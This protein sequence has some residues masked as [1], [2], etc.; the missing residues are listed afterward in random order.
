MAN[1]L[2]HFLANKFPFNE[3]AFS[4]GKLSK[5]F[6]GICIMSQTYYIFCTSLIFVLVDL[7]NVKH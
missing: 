3:P 7:Y 4:E 1:E 2:A 5:L 6:P